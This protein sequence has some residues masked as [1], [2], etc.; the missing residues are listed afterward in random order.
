MEKKDFASLFS[1]DT[2]GF[3]DGFYQDICLL[4]NRLEKE[5]LETNFQGNEDLNSEISMTESQLF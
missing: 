4:K 2:S 5:M 1:N 3:D